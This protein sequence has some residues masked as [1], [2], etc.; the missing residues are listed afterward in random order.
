M[1]RDMIDC[2]MAGG[3]L[4][5]LPVWEVDMTQQ[6]VIALG[7][8]VLCYIVMLAIKNEPQGGNP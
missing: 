4:S 7:L 2:L 3:L 6:I 5:F 1:I 8:A